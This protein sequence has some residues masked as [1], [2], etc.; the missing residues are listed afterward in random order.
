M[1]LDVTKAKKEMKAHFDHQ[2]KKTWLMENALDGILIH[3]SKEHY[4]NNFV[5]GEVFEAVISSSVTLRRRNLK[6]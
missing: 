4:F 1:S 6:T 5:N 3:D 2:C